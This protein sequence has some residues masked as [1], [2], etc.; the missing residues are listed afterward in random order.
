MRKIIC[1]ATAVSLLLAG[2]SATKVTATEA[3][4]PSI[5]STDESAE[6]R[7][8]LDY[9]KG[10]ETTGFLVTKDGEVLVEQNWP[11]PDTPG[12]RIF[13]HGQSNSGALWEDVASQQKSF[14]AVLVGIAVDKGLLDLE[15]PVSDYLG[16]GWSNA[17]H[18]QEEQ[19]LVD[20]VLMMNTGLDENFEYEAPPGTRFLYNTPVYAVSKQILTEASGLSLEQLTRDWLTEPAGMSET[21]WRQRPPALANVGNATGLVTTPRDTARFGQLVLT[22]GVGENG[23]RVI[24]E[25][26]VRAM[27]M[28]S[29]TNPAYGRLWWLNGSEYVML[30]QGKHRNG[31]LIP[32]APSDLVAA[33][34]FLDRKLYIVPSLNLV[35]VRTGADAPDKA[36]D[37]HLWQRLNA[38][39]G[40]D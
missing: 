24:S 20:H 6:M 3:S 30:A 14:I 16:R 25:A 31:E 1:G 39:L 13:L 40:I 37:E 22:G 15:A 23:I 32:S 10:Q 2:C 27:F 28:R 12:F 19:I 33:L 4:G 11:A 26:S 7:E 29:E 5:A 35:V 9:L 34:G 8:L 17:A 36:F 21:A 38:V 18:E